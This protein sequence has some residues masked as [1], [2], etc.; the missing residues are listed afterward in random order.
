MEET[1]GTYAAERKSHYAIS[2]R[3][4]NF[5]HSP[6]SVI[7]AAQEPSSLAADVIRSCVTQLVACIVRLHAMMN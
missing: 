7:G 6:N 4:A 1:D 5:S 2:S 3:V